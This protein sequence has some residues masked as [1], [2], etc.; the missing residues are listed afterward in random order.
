MRHSVWRLPVWTV[1]CSLP[2]AISASMF[3]MA[4]SELPVTRA[5]TDSFVRIET[6]ALKLGSLSWERVRPTIGGSVAGGLGAGVME[7]TMSFRTVGWVSPK[8]PVST[9]PP[10]ASA[11]TIRT[12]PIPR[13]RPIPDRLAGGSTGATTYAAPHP[14]QL[15]C[16]GS[17]AL[18]QRRQRTYLPSIPNLLSAQR[19]VAP[20][21][22]SALRDVLRPDPDEPQTQLSVL[23]RIGL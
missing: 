19:A 23:L 3:T 17:K 16:S 4:V 9:I 13:S 7:T 6:W 1:P 5:L 22:P 10:I 18:W 12:A 21:P 11:S 20:I 15:P 2:P 8:A 14:G